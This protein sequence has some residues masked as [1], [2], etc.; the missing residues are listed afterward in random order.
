LKVQPESFCQ[1]PSPVKGS[2]NNIKR[3]IWV[4]NLEKVIKIMTN[5]GRKVMGKNPMNCL[6]EKIENVGC[7]A[8]PK[9]E[10]EL[11]V[12]APFPLIAQ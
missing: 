12:K 3:G 1:C 4:E 11:I 10:K 6:R 5:G 9:H 8:Q 2:L 7:R